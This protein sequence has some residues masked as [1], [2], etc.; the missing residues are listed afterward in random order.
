[1]SWKKNI[2]IKQAAEILGVDISTARRYFD[3]GRLEPKQCPNCFSLE[4]V[5]MA[6]PSKRK[7]VRPD[8]K[9]CRTCKDCHRTFP[10]ERLILEGF[11]NPMNNFRRVFLSSARELA[12]VMRVAS[13]V[14]AE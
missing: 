11:R 5:P 8:Q 4:T 1:M 14:T 9:P 6:T 10:E 12:K 7:G 3:N 2:G 13:K